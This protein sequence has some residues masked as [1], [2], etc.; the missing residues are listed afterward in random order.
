MPRPPRAPA[1]PVRAVSPLVLCLVLLPPAFLGTPEPAA[2]TPQEPEPELNV[3]F[4][5]RTWTLTWACRENVTVTMCIVTKAGGP[6]PSTKPRKDACGCTFRR[7]L[8][9]QGLSLE[10]QATVNRTVIRQKLAYVNPGANGTAAQNLSCSIHLASV[11]MCT[12]EPGPVA[13]PDVQYYLYIK[14]LSERTEWE[15]PQYL[16]DSVVHTGCRVQNLSGL[17]SESYVLLNGTSRREAIQFL[18]AMLDSK[19]IERLSAPH[20]ITVTCNASHCRVTWR[21]PRTWARLSFWDFKYELDIQRQ[22][23]DPGR[24]NPTISVSSNADDKYDFPS[25]EPRPL[26]TARIRAGDVRSDK[27]S[28]WSPEVTFGSGESRFPLLYVYVAVVLLTVFCALGLGFACKRV[29]HARSLFPPIPQI[30]DKVTDS[31]AADPQTLSNFEPSVQ[32]AEPEEFTSVEE[33]RT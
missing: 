14:D 30:K 24:R 2:V 27:W 7:L 20:N 12:W 11:M 18:D 25:P 6:R 26:H 31:D 28:P 33:V 32:K 19:E 29:V 23:V 22:N 8:L 9:H 21:R 10:V 5:P 13:P 4:N 1:L 15:C 17:P 3:T 16:G